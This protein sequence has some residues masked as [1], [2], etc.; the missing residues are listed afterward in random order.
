ML[1]SVPLAATLFWLL[2]RRYFDSQL[3]F[4]EYQQFAAVVTVAVAG[5]YQLYFWV[6]RNQSGRRPVCLKIAFD[7]RIPF[8]P[9]W[10]WLYSFLYYLVIGL[11]VVSIRDLGEGVHIIFG[12]LLL[13]L[14]GSVIFY[15]YPTYVPH[16]F[17]R[18]KANTPSTRY[19]AFVQS[20]DNTR[21]AFPSMH[22]ALATY[23]GLV[24]MELPSVGV[25][26][27]SLYIGFI[28]ASC[29]LVKQ[30]VIV[31]TIAGVALGMLAFGFNEMLPGWLAA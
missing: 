4:L 1:V 2:G 23:V 14:S 18:F 13:L 9:Q 3:R 25:W 12:G 26:V 21:N 28:G 16:R 30:H 19:L 20:M 22:C 7:D 15:F 6:Q 11:T 27:G 10:I 5:G 17:R 29:L 24:V 31:D 8:I